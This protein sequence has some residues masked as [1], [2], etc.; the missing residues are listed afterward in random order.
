MVVR[1][2]RSLEEPVRHAADT[3]EQPLGIYAQ[4]VNGTAT[5][6]KDADEAEAG[7]LGDGANHISL[8][9]FGGDA[10]R[11]PDVPSL[12]PVDATEDRVGG[13]LLRQDTIGLKQ[14]GKDQ[15]NGGIEGRNR[16]KV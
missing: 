3:R 16:G 5:P 12:V 6:S 9:E 4:A 7:I 8:S 10:A 14:R 13:R 15:A 1:K 11:Q 2:G